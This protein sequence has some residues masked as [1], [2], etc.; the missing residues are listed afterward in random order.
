MKQRKKLLAT[1]LAVIIVCGVSFGVAGAAP[2]AADTGSAPAQTAE[3]V[4]ETAQSTAAPAAFTDVPAGAW[5]AEA[6]NW[7]LSQGILTGT[8]LEPDSAMTRV[9]VSGRAQWLPV[10]KRGGMGFREQRYV[11]L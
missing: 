7:C 11:R 2:D 1:L 6:A 9:T 8:A 4:T 10:R 5:Y 3:P